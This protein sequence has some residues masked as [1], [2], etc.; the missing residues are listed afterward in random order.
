MM[1]L[2]KKN[3]T[4]YWRQLSSSKSRGHPLPEYTRKQ[5]TDWCLKSEKFNLPLT[6]AYTEILHYFMQKS[7]TKDF[8][9]LLREFPR[10]KYNFNK[11]VKTHY[12]HDILK[13]HRKEEIRPL[14]TILFTF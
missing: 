9:K 11:L 7:A 3:N 12:G 10:L 5:L 6:K 2:E 4:L 14:G 1:S 13:K 8:D